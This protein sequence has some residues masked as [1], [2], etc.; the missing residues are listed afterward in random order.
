MTTVSPPTWKP[1]STKAAELVVAAAQE[2]LLDP[3]ALLGAGDE[4]ILDALP[5]LASDTDLAAMAQATNHANVT[6]W[7]VSMTRHPGEPVGRDLTPES[8]EIAR[9]IVRRGIDREVLWTGYRRGQNATWCNWMQL[10]CRLSASIPESSDALGEAL[11]ATARSFFGFVD[12][13]L[14]NVESQVS[15]ERDQLFGGTPLRME[16]VQLIL[17][18]APISES[19]A[20]KRLGYDLT[21]QHVGFVLWSEGEVSQGSLEKAAHKLA[22]AAGV[23]RP[24]T[25][26]VSASSLWAWAPSP[27]DPNLRGMRSAVVD[28]GLP[29][30]IAIGTRAP[31][32]TGFA[33]THRQALDARKLAQRLSKPARFTS[34]QEIE[35]VVLAGG[36]LDR[37]SQF[38]QR[39]LGCLRD[40]R[41]E[42]RET[43]LA[44]YRH[45]RNA[46]SAAKELFTH[47]NTV[48]NRLAR[49][50][51]LLPRPSAER[52]LAVHLALELD[53]WLTSPRSS[54]A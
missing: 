13:I 37:A 54:G 49:A 41:P 11:N 3:S 44:Y 15:L 22:R 42:V 4:S 18:G 26:P 1:L 19:R 10:L 17:E 46:T 21:K 5:V 14:V 36:D 7:L 51:E 20:S 53:F 31:G 12:D 34:Y 2:V 23:G 32:M 39:T 43:L 35:V 27:T 24:L 16:A 29:I 52:P 33:L 6:R 48:V 50:E 9:D 47:R 45:E 38:V 28:L 30:H 8:L 40:E 25:L